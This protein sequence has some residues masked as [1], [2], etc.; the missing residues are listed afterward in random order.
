MASKHFSPG[1]R[2]RARRLRRGMSLRDV[3]KAS[4]GL[5]KKLHSSKFIVPASRLHGFETSNSVPSAYRFYT[6]AR[7]YDCTL[8]ELLAWYGIP[9]K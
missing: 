2:L 7:L 4:V 1:K 3:Q 6:L 9:S 5:A 8:T